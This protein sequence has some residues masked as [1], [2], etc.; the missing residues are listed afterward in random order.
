M[1]ELSNAERETHISQCADNR[2]MW[3]IYTDDP[4]WQAR[5]QKL[6]IEPFKTI[7]EGMWCTVPA[8]QV[9]IRKAK[10]KLTEAESARLAERLSASRKQGAI[11]P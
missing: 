7:G 11:A 3:E 10:R 5:L 1:V 4:V 2:A 8:A 9:A 6:G